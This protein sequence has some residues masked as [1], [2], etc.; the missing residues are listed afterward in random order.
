MEEKYRHAKKRVR[1]CLG[2]EGWGEREAG[3]ERRGEIPTRNGGL[4]KRVRGCCKEL[5]AHQGR[6]RERGRQSG[7]TEGWGEREGWERGEE[8]VNGFGIE[9]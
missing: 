4:K 8:M 2:T 1:A 3:G 7:G 9:K 6:E 5:S